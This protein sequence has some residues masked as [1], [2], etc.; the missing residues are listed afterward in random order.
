M[1][2]SI[3]ILVN[4]LFQGVDYRDW[5]NVIIFSEESIFLDYSSITGTPPSLQSPQEIIGAWSSFVPGFDKTHHQ[6]SE[7]NINKEDNFTTVTFKGKADH[8]IGNSV[9]TVEGDYLIKINND[10]RVNLMK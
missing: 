6:L 10:N 2:N 7:F 3:T 8:F 9:W 1:K 4:E 5:E